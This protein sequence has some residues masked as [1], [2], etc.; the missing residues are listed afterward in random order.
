MKQLICRKLLELMKTQHYESI[1]VTDLVKYIGIGRSTF[2]SHFDSIYSVLQYIEDDF[3][4][5]LPTP[6]TNIKE[7]LISDRRVKTEYLNHVKKNKQ[8][9]LVLHGPNGD[10]SFKVRLANHSRRVLASI[11]TPTGSTYSAMERRAIYEFYQGGNDR[12][13]SWWLEHDDDISVSN[14]VTLM[15]QLMTDIFE[16]LFTN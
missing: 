10:P 13:I 3:I 2:Y 4:A 12:L 11:S 6:D 9:Y 1:K 14:M 16:R 7:T 5:G 8:T 15:E